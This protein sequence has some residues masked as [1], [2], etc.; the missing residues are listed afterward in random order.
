MG[1]DESTLKSKIQK[2]L[3][4]RLFKQNPSPKAH[5]D[6]Q[7]YVENPH[8]WGQVLQCDKMVEDIVVD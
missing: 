1:R 4:E 2:A 5:S 7:S 3:A 6:N 8:R